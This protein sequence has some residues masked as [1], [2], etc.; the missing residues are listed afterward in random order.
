MTSCLVCKGSGILPTIDGRRVC[1]KCLGC[2]AAFFN[3]YFGPFKD[4]PPCIS[5]KGAGVRG[6]YIGDNVTCEACNGS[7]TL[8]KP[9]SVSNDRPPISTRTCYS[10]MGS[11]RSE[12]KNGRM[13]CASCSGNGQC[14]SSTYFGLSHK[15]KT[16]SKCNG[17]GATGEYVGDYIACVVCKGMGTIFDNSEAFRAGVRGCPC[18]YGPAGDDCNQRNN[19]GMGY[20]NN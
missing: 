4:S 3:I 6:E 11:G 20:P 10:C 1:S 2:G 13:Q 18:S 9:P 17:E 19:W 12:T 5:C 8:N 7:G 15:W 16:C 14:R